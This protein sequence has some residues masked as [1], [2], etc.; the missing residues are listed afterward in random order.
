MLYCVLFP[1]ICKWLGNKECERKSFPLSEVLV[2][3]WK[4]LVVCP[5]A[6][7]PKQSC[8]VLFEV[9][10]VNAIAADGEPSG[11][12]VCEVEKCSQIGL[13]KAFIDDIQD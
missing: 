11:S 7:K 13:D 3:E 1:C 10:V 2:N 6:A 5:N 4:A 9:L 12:P 8:V